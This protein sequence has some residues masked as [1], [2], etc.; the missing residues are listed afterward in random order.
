MPL[1]A[2]RLMRILCGVFLLV[3]LPSSA[4]T[5]PEPK[6]ITISSQNGNFRLTIKPATQTESREC[7][8]TL[9]K[10]NND[11][12]SKLIWSR[13]LINNECPVHA[14]VSNDGLFVVTFDEWSRVG[15]LPIVVYDQAGRLAHVC[16][17]Q[18]LGLVQ[19]SRFRITVGS[20]WWNEDA[21]IAF[22]KSADTKYL[23]I[24]L[25]TGDLLRVDLTTGIVFGDTVA[26]A[27]TEDHLDKLREMYVDS[28]KKLLSICLNLFRSEDIKQI[29]L[30]ADLCKKYCLIEM[31][32]LLKNHLKEIAPS[33][34]EDY[35]TR[36]ISE[37]TV[38]QGL[39]QEEARTQESPL[40]LV[41]GVLE[42]LKLVQVRQKVLADLKI[43]NI[44]SFR[45]VTVDNSYLTIIPFP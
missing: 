6:E 14:L 31:S 23:T 15:H 22:D 43:E 24:W 13:N 33:M 18:T 20:R 35:A 29:Q 45:R 1:L 11:N 21:L 27:L 38:K 42:Y 30:A 10:V 40:N 25:K 41:I 39:K 8:A 44:E 12:E 34:D 2:K 16:T 5:W 7:K 3:C 32:F 36:L 26:S 37:L 28:R 4:D 9:Y 19:D 17:L